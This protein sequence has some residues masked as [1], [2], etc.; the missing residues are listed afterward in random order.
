[1][2]YAAD[3]LGGDVDAASIDASGGRGFA[4]RVDGA[5]AGRVAGTCVGFDAA[6][7]AA[8]PGVACGRADASRGGAAAAGL[9]PPVDRV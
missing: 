4:A 6:P 1:M 2:N 8:G 7:R 3:G 5:L 9:P